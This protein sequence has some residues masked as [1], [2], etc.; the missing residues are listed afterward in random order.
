MVLACAVE[1]TLSMRPQGLHAL[2]EG[3]EERL[4]RAP[5]R[6][7]EVLAQGVEMGG[8]GASSWIDRIIPPRPLRR[9]KVGFLFQAARGERGTGKPL[10][11]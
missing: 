8:P 5:C 2:P 4:P 7:G 1:I 6:L 3:G 9:P 10:C 11:R